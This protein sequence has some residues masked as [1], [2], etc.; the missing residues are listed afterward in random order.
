MLRSVSVPHDVAS[1]VQVRRQL[2]ADLR[3]CGLA[4]DSVR[5][6]VLLGS[7]LVGNAVR[8][9]RP[10]PDGT[11]RVS[12]QITGG[13]LRLTVTDGGTGTGTGAPHLV[14]ADPTATAGRG[15]SI[16]DA[17]AS[18]WGVETTDGSTQVWVAL[19][20]RSGAAAG[21]PRALARLAAPT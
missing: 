3:E 12:W 18:L 2:A 14:S 17:I 9:A 1:A 6:A 15:L 20:A 4:E 16:V 7:E 21:S 11:V 13:R 5:D 10:L 19:P 8:H